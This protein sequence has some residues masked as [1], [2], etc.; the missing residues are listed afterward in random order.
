MARRVLHDPYFKKA[1]EEGYLARSAFKLQQINQNKRLIRRGDRVLDLG[2]APGAWLQVASELVGPKGTV[3]GIDLK[4]VTAQLAANITHRVGDVE[5]IDP[6]ELLAL[7]S[8]VPRMYDVVLS[9]MAPNTTGHGDDLVSA[10]LCDAVLALVPA[11]LKPTGHLVM[12]ILEGAETPRILKQ[13][14]RGFVQAGAHKPDAS[15]DVSRETYLFGLGWTGS[16]RAD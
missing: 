1:K 12:K 4:P 15:R 13:L 16:P 5:S 3:V 6:T 2:C 10:R 14:R 11:V 8:P 9:D 7:G